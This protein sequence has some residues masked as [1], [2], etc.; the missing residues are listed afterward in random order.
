MCLAPSGTLYKHSIPLHPIEE[1]TFKSNSMPL[2]ALSVPTES[3]LE[4]LIGMRIEMEML[5]R[6][7]GSL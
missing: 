2:G 3:I 6:E 1:G 7:N 4:N 5:N